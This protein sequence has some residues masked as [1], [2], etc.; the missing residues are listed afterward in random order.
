VGFE[1]TFSVP[2]V[3]ATSRV[4]QEHGGRIVMERTTITGVGHLVW[5]EDPGQRRGRHAIR[6]RSRVNTWPG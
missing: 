1:C 5:F 3:D 6:Q 4:V 2:D